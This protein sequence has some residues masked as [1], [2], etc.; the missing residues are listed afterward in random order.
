MILALVLACSDYKL[1]LQ[2]D[3]PEAGTNVCDDV[4]APAPYAVEEDPACTFAPDPGTF[5]PVVEWQWSTASGAAGYDDVM[6]MPAVGDLDG[7]GVP[8]VVVT[9]YAGTNYGGAGALEILAGDGSGEK[10]AYTSIGGYTPAA[11]AGVALGDV[12]G[13]GT[14]EIVTLTTDLRVIALHMDGTLIWASDAYPNDFTVY[15]YPALA[16]MN[17][18]GH[19]EVVVGRVILDARGGHLGT[20][21]AGWGGDY[22]IS[23]VVDL[24]GDGQQ[25]VVV[26]NA[27]YDLHGNAK[28]TNALSDGWV[29]VGDFDLDGDG[30]IATVTGGSV[31]LLDTDGTTLWGPV[32]VPGGGGGPPTV[33]DFDG[34]G[35]PEVGVAGATGYAVYDTDG[36][37]LWTAPTTD[38]SSARTGSSVFDFEGDGASEVVYADE[39]TLWV[40]DG[41]TGAPILA[42]DGHSSWTLFEYPVIADVDGDGEAEIVLASNDSINPGWQGVTVIGDASRSWAPTSPVWNQHAWY[43]DNVN[44]DLTIPASPQPN[45]VTGHNSFRAGGVREGPGNPAPNLTTSATVLC[46]Q[47]DPLEAQVAVQVENRGTADATGPVSVALY[48][49][50]HGGSDRDLVGVQQLPE[51]VPAGETGATLIFDVGA[52]FLDGEVVFVARADDDGTHASTVTE[53]DEDDNAAEVTTSCE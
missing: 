10:A 24:D 6:M 9:S 18:D 47:C 31:Y 4:E 12:D 50:R 53:C 35:L 27:A 32:A 36:T 3:A 19:V 43:I 45:W 23:V 28:W 7:D 26:G 40:Y 41:A 52:E 16:D 2:H 15:S 17:A 38:A 51:G 14:P 22:A 13:D 8:E 34:D 20:G 30:E 39:L 21:T 42:D 49:S 29:A 37:I 33:A 25:E 44:D 11:S 5:D 1:D 48:R 46:F